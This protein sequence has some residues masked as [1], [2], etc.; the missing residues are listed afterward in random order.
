MNIQQTAEQKLVAAHKPDYMTLAEAAD[1][2][3]NCKS[4]ALKTL[5]EPC[6]ILPTAHKVRL[7]RRE[8]VLEAKKNL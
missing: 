8:R 6:K 1:Y 3:G 7:W 4:K 5:G 2:F